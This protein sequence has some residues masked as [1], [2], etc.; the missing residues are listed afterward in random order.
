MLRLEP[1]KL[2]K[3]SAKTPERNVTEPVKKAAQAE[4]KVGPVDHNNGLFGSLYPH[5]SKPPEKE[6][7][8]YK[9]SKSLGTFI[10]KKTLPFPQPDSYAHIDAL[11][12]VVGAILFNHRPVTKRLQQS[13][14][15]HSIGDPMREFH[16][17]LQELHQLLLPVASA[18]TLSN[19]QKVDWARVDQIKL[20]LNDL[21]QGLHTTDVRR[22]PIYHL[23]CLITTVSNA[24]ALIVAH[25][26]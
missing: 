7:T 11:R 16:L 20:R 6:S 19:L 4:T 13:Y 26:D 18:L 5:P 24:Q 21:P 23:E 15:P 14:D 2:S 10:A 17:M 22:Q 25:H 1:A 12:S 8:R 3:P 9:A